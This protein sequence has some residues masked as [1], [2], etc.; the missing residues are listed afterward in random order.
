MAD[1]I[2]DRTRD[3]ADLD[4]LM[5]AVLHECTYKTTLDTVTGYVAVNEFLGKFKSWNEKTST[6]PSGRHL[7]LYKALVTRLHF[8]DPDEEAKLEGIR[9]SLTQVHVNLI[10]YC[11]KFRYSLGGW[12]HIINAMILKSSGNYRIHRLRIIHLY[13][14]DF[15]FILGIKWR[16]L[17]HH[18]DQL[19]L[20]HGGQYGGT[21]QTRG[22][23]LG[24]ARC[25]R[26]SHT[27]GPR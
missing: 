17:L 4:K 12:Q 21:P 27:S 1:A 10:N 2:L 26:H 15:N 6:S 23:H 5:Q 22:G 14:A 19:Q 16:Q 24:L 25:V 7:G 3:N 9:K 11:L 13:E 8:Q 20:V 18:A